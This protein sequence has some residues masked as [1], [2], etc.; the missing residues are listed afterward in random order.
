MSIITANIDNIDDE[1]N[2]TRNNEYFIVNA[3][4]I[5]AFEHAMSVG[6]KFAENLYNHD[7][8]VLKR[9]AQREVNHIRRAV[10]F[11]SSYASHLLYAIHMNMYKRQQVIAILVFAVNNRMN[12]TYEDRDLLD[13]FIFICL[14]HVRKVYRP[15]DNDAFDIKE[16]TSHEIFNVFKAT[17]SLS[18]L[19]AL[20]YM[21]KYASQRTYANEVFGRDTIDAVEALRN[22]IAFARELTG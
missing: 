4:K 17:S 21:F 7:R 16:I 22:S 9:R 11:H 15:K 10:I 19:N 14:Q 8:I 13:C 18:H 2:K 6:L 1:Y 12:I 3:Q 20:K 5:A